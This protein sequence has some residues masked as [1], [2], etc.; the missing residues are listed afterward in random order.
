MSARDSV[1][2]LPPLA[3][4]DAIGV[5]IVGIIF[6]KFYRTSVLPKCVNGSVT[7]K[8]VQHVYHHI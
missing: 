4:E 7:F 1:V 5:D 3:R 8:K 6:A 2:L